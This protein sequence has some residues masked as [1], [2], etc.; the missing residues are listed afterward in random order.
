VSPDI[1]QSRLSFHLLAFL[2]A[3]RK[4]YGLCSDLGGT[5]G[6]TFLQGSRLLE[7]TAHHHDLFPCGLITLSGWQRS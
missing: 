3:R 1:S 7:S 5:V 6:N 4:G 2:A